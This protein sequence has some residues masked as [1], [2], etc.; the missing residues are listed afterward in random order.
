[1]LPLVGNAME[2][3]PGLELQWLTGF[4]LQLLLS[5]VRVSAFLISAPAFGARWFPLQVRV[6]LAFMLIG[7]VFVRVEPLDMALIGSPKI[8]MILATEVAVGLT[9]GLTLTIWFSA[10]LLA[11][12]KIATSAGLGF[13]AQL[14]P[15]T[16][17]QTPVVSQ[18]LYLFLTVLFFSMDGH[19]LV[20]GMMLASYDILPLGQTPPFGL[21]IKSVI[22]AAGAMFF[23]ASI[24]MMPVALVL[25]M[26]NA[27]IGIITR[28]APQLNLF[29]FGFPISLLA[30]FFILFLSAGALGEAF[31]N[32]I[33]ASL[34]SLETLIGGLG[35]G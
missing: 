9:A 13:A 2:A 33:N 21:L 30:V 22:E 28:S 34:D 6:M 18:M 17:A 5:S 31:T 10:A 14:D 24:I 1:M 35:D 16:G 11:G 4:L 27:S 8:I 32:L 26:V 20:L 7:I 23:A 3:L 19:L 12:E 29:S 15:Q 25:L